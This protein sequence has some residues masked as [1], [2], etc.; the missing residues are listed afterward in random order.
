VFRKI[1]KIVTT[2]AL[3][4]AG[5][6]GYTRGFAF[7]T[8]RVVP[9]TSVPRIPADTSLTLTARETV[10]L[11]ARAFGKEHWTTSTEDS[12]SYYDA[13][14]GYW[15]FFKTYARLNGGRRVHF[16]PF[17]LIQRGKKGEALKTIISKSADIDFDKPFDMGKAGADPAR[18]VRARLDGD[19]RLRDDKGTVDRPED[20][21]TVSTKRR[22]SKSGPWN[23]RSPCV[24]GR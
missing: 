3:L 8:A 13:Q 20:D 14:R 22:R 12:V 5:Y 21:L 19:V 23:R 17:A 1:L 6:A 2:F 4:V 16:E 24:K 9:I 10:R 15:M 18:V 11:A 7:V